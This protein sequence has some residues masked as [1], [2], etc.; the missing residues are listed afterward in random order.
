MICYKDVRLFV[1]FISVPLNPLKQPNQL[2]LHFEE[3]F[4]LSEIKKKDTNISIIQPF[5]ENGNKIVYQ[6]F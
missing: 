1:F 4:N 5:M 6:G 3:T 2:S